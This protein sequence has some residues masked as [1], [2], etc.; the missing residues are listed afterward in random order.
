[1]SAMYNC[2][3]CGHSATA[4]ELN[5]PGVVAPCPQCGRDMYREQESGGGLSRQRG[6]PARGRGG[7]RT[8]TALPSRYGG[9]TVSRYDADDDY[10]EYDDDDSYNSVMKPYIPF[11]AYL[12]LIAS[13]VPFICIAGL[14][15]SVMAYRM[16]DEN[17]KGLRGKG[18][19]IA[20]IAL[21][22]LMTLLTIILYI[23]V[24]F[25]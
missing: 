3:S 1:M 9:S 22:S 10:D 6:V 13:F 7:A 25:G 24:R 19:A 11:F 17:P 20:G 23:R 2:L 18:V 5:N 4:A 12:G 16:I 21:G 15:F 14:I 8:S